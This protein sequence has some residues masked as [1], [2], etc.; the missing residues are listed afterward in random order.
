MAKPLAPLRK[1]PKSIEYT[2]IFWS[3]DYFKMLP[4]FLGH[5]QNQFNLSYLS[6]LILFTLSTSLIIH[7]MCRYII[8][9]HQAPLKN[10]DAHK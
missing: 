5:I 9:G 7:I 3:L 4:P 2:Y 8:I 10:Q 1:A 6:T